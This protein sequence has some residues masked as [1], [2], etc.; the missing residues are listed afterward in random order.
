MNQGASLDTGASGLPTVLANDTDADSPAT[1]LKAAL[2][3]GPGHASAFVLNADGSFSYTPEAGFAGTDTFTYKAN[4]GT[5]AGPPSAAMSPDSNEITV[6]IAVVDTTPPVVT[7]SI[8]A[9]DGLGGY[10]VSTPVRVTVSATDASGVTA[11]ACADGET[12]IAAGSVT[13]LGS[14]TARG[15]LS[16][17]G[18]GTHALICTATNGAGNTGAAAGSANTGTVKIDVVPPTAAITTPVNDGVYVLNASVTASYACADPAPGSGL[19]SCNGTVAVG[20]RINTSSVGSKTFALT[21][22]DVAGNQT[23]TT[24][25]YLVV[26]PATISPLKSSANL[27]SAVPVSW[28][29]RD[30]LGLSISSLTTL[31]KMESVFNGAVP[32]TGVCVASTTGIRQELYSPATGATGGSDFRLVTGGYRFNWDTTT[33]LGTGEG[34]YTVLISLNDGSAPKL[35]TAV[36]LK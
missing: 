6:S 17:S 20:S 30:A 16:V 26:Y 3:T 22:T 24:Y 25:N 33:A 11:F 5:W 35:T 14:S 2:G 10:F 32:A 4:D 31:L 29:L 15:S 27:V 28:Q 34:C 12:A 19:A 13:G 8:P 9:P 21:A 7:L 36:Q 23:T 1:S 18:T